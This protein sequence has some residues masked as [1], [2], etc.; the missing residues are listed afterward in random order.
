MEKKKGIRKAL[1]THLSK[2]KRMPSNLVSFSNSGHSAAHRLLSAC[3]YPRTPSMGAGRHPGATLSDIDR[4][5]RDNFR[6]LYVH[7]DEAP[8]GS[9]PRSD[10][11]ALPSEEE[12]EKSEGVAVTTVSVDPYRDFRRSIE[13]MVEARHAEAADLDWDFMEE[14][15]L[16]YLEL[17]HGRVHK[18]IL[19]AFADL[20]VSFGRS[21]R[22]RS[23][24]TEGTEQARTSPP[25]AKIC[26]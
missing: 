24:V 16:C 12:D 8:P 10:A 18:H 9:S 7:D 25:R 11:A 20:A 1:Q 15:L 5:L 19:M 13:E 17:N 14:L 4:F 23:S 26:K 2:L 6:S 22:W 3:K 21:R